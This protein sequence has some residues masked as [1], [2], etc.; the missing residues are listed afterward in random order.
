MNILLSESD[1]GTLRKKLC[2][3]VISSIAVIS[4][5][6]IIMVYNGI[7]WF[8]NPSEEEFPVRGIDV[9]EYQ[10]EIDWQTLSKQNIDFVLI[11]ATEGSGYTD[12]C[13]AY[14]FDEAQKTNLR[15]GA[16]HFFSYDSEGATQAENFISVVGTSYD[17]LPP[18]VDVEF[19]GDYN[20][21]P[22]DRDDVT[23]RLNAFL[24]EIESFYGVK[25]IIYATEK[26]YKLYISGEYIDY[27]IW[28]RNV[29]TSP[30]LP[31]GRKWTFWQYS[32][33]AVLPGYNGEEKYIDM[34]V[35]NG[36]NEIFEEF[37]Q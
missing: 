36:D 29:L 7:I 17:T 2:I 6:I 18:V 25:P 21:T 15:V 37:L 27:P 14:N 10:G 16:Y 34:N 1:V 22:P 11:K 24:N 9:S 31:D 23:P 28:I 33:R 35:F 32:D 19:Y 20:K 8:N 5:A 13:F 30:T 4:A 12:S 26:S 3:A